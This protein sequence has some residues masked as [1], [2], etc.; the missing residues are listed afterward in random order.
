MRQVKKLSPGAILAILIL[1]TAV[2]GGHRFSINGDDF[3]TICAGTYPGHPRASAPAA[4][5]A[6]MDAAE[7]PLP[8]C[9]ACPIVLERDYGDTPPDSAIVIVS[10]RI[11]DAEIAYNGKI[12]ITYQIVASV[13]GDSFSDISLDCYDSDGILRDSAIIMSS[14][15]DGEQFRIFESACIPMDTAEI[16]ITAN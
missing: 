2:C 5:A 6:K 16:R 15:K 7:I 13:I 4:L 9:P 10:F 3:Q 14:N 12:A 8:Q 11:S 1:T